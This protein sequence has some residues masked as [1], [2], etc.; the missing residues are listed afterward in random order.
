[1]QY[2]YITI[3]H[4][5][6]S[7]SVRIYFV[8][9]GEPI[10]RITFCTSRFPPLDEFR[11]ED[12]RSPSSSSKIEKF[13][14][15][16][17]LRSTSST[18]I[19]RVRPSATITEWNHFATRRICLLLVAVWYFYSG[20]WTPSLRDEETHRRGKSEQSNQFILTAW[21]TLPPCCLRFL[22]NYVT[23]FHHTYKLG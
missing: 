15:Q 4:Y 10:R 20:E 12:S 21:W 17:V 23:S 11:V 2:F 7:R 9:I 22:R 18:F 5:P 8:Y 13:Y 1:M 14:D 16:R 3:L 6:M 19:L